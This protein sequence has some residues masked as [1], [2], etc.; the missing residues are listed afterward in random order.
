MEGEVLEEQEEERTGTGAGEKR[1]AC[2]V[3]ERC[4]SGELAQAFE[5]NSV[6]LMEVLTGSSGFSRLLL[7]GK[8]GRPI[9]VVANF[10]RHT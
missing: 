3:C 9:F 10:L 8:E 2:G 7:Q 4:D 6:V 5:N 1:A